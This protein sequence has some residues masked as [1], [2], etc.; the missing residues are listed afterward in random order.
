MSEYR[1]YFLFNQKKCTY[2]AQRSR[3]TRD[4]EKKKI[5]V[6]NMEKLAYIPKL[7]GF[8]VRRP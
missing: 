4:F 7:L 8:S 5:S 2:S 1:E 3:E 6:R